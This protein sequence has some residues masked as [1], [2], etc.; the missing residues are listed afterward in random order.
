MGTSCLG[1]GGETAQTVTDH[2]AAGVEG[3][4]CHLCDLGAITV[5]Y[6]KV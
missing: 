5:D 1:D 6:S 3:V 4:F 2:A